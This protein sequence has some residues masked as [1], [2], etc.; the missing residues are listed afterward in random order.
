M[1]GVMIK[2]GVY[3][4]L[5]VLDF[6]GPAPAWW[7]GLLVGVGLVSGLGGVLLALTQ[8]DL[9]R[10]LAYSSVENVGII[11][12]A[13][14]FALVAQGH[15]APEIAALAWA[16]ALLQVWNHALFKSALFLA[17]G[18]LAHGTGTLDLAR[19]GGVLR[20]MPCT[21]GVFLVGAAA[22]CALPGTN[23]FVSE[24]LVLGAAFRRIADPGAPI[25]A[26]LA[27]LAGLGLL[28]GLAVACFARAGGIALLGQPRSGA[29][30]AA[31]ES[32]PAMRGAMLVLAAG[33]VLLGVAGPLELAATRHV[34]SA[35]LGADRAAADA[36][37]SA[38][39]ALWAVGG[40]ATAV[41][42]VALGVA[43]LRRRLLATR[44]PEIGTTWDCG[45]AAP[46]PR[47]QYTASSFAEPLTELFGPLLPAGGRPREPRDL[48]PGPASFATR[49]S[50]PGAELFAALFRA[51][52][53]LSRR[54]RVLQSG[55]THLYVL[56]VALATL[57]LLIWKLG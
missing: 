29:I 36:L 25:Q 42:I 21:G 7:G 48:F 18:S 47:M 3:G 28:A 14:G 5:R 43:G 39:P 35:A 27:V 26:A 53:A 51:V 46:T 15:G 22:V 41:G 6:L 8:H 1:S 52:A 32:G 4:L 19:L 17:A 57:G 23:G 49:V 12:L 34:V 38:A 54:V 16:G 31:H 2:T 45:Y 10:L 50:D 56:Y 37:G 33:C 30:D 11:L 44:G 24:F 9:K 13:I 20:R 55:S 40:V